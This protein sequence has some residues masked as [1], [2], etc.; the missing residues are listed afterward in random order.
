MDE[1]NLPSI[2]L[3]KFVINIGSF[4][5]NLS[6]ALCILLSLPIIVASGEKSFSKLKQL[7]K[8][9]LR[10]TMTNYPLSG[11]AIDDNMIV[12]KHYVKC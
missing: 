9:Y 7:T 8:S 6:F 10:S 12:I 3:L 1:S 4:A 11:L 2:E 5:P